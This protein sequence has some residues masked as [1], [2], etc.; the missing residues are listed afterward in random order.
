MFDGAV[1]TARTIEQNFGVP[2]RAYL[3]ETIDTYGMPDYNPNISDIFGMESA[4]VF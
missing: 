4:H 2:T 3:T 1:I